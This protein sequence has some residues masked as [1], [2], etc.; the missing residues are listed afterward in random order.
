MQKGFRRILSVAF[1]IILGIEAQTYCQTVEDA[2]A[3]ASVRADR[4]QEAFSRSRRVVRAWYAFKGKNNFL[5]PDNHGI[6]IWRPENAAADLW[7]FFV[8]S[9]R[10]TDREMFDGPILKTLEDEIRLT[11]RLGN[12]P[13]SYDIDRNRFLRPEENAPA[14]IFGASEYV[15]DGLLPI[16]EVMGRTVWFERGRGILDDIFLHA[17]VKTEFGNIPSSSAEV[18]GEMLQNL[19]R[20]YFA[21]GD[22]RYREWA[23]RIGDAYFLSALPAC[24]GLPCHDWDFT[25]GKPINDLL[26]MSDHGNEIVFGLAEILALEYNCGPDKFA[27]YLP[28]MR[29]M[30]DTLLEKCVNEDGLWRHTIQPSSLKVLNFGTPDTWGYALNAVYTMYLVTGEEKYRDAVV[31]A[32]RGINAKPRYRDWGGADAFADSIES[33]ILLL[34]RIPE[35]AGFEWLEATVPAFLKKQ[36]ED[37]IVEGWHGDGNYIRTALMYA[38]MNTRGTHAEPWREDVK[39]GA[40]ESVDMLCVSVNCGAEWSGR[41][42]FD[43]PRHRMHMGLPMNY[44]RLNEFPEWF[45]AE[46]TRLYAVSVN[47]GNP[48]TMLGQRLIDGLPLQC[49]PGET[50]VTVQVIEGPPYEV[51]LL[52][53]IAPPAFGA[54]GEAAIRFSAVNMSKKAQTVKFSASMGT[55][56]PDDVRMEPQ[57]AAEFVLNL[58]I[59]KPGEVTIEAAPEGGEKSSAVVRLAHRENLVGFAAFAHE[60]YKGRAYAFLGKGTIQ[61]ALPAK[62]GKAHTLHLLW[63]SKNDE[64]TAILI[65]NGLRLN[66]KKGGY[67]GFEWLS[68]PIP[69]ENVAENRI[70]IKI[71]KDPAGGNGAFI[72]EIMVTAP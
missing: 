49:G 41:L 40:A 11:S 31:R 2:W 29:R 37:G 68:V 59:E 63:G 15:K 1:L 38:F 45:A 72:S 25:A 39:I 8:I 48:E 13:D 66:L 47:G 61:C 26:S 27:Q 17:P 46:P 24:N 60:E 44:P 4:A 23:E 22:K 19:S 9:T 55:V 12:L 62:P 5:L 54:D 3:L 52:R 10:F 34:N 50:R 67:D 20:F 6:R 36:R 21:T 16:A 28:P 18:N 70:A 35:P 58:K 65:A 64:R 33:G 51:E 71:E 42:H 32:L 56:Q 30:I 57:A 43:Y 69:A 7:S 53:I 14:I